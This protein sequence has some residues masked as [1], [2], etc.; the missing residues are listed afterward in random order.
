MTVIRSHAKALRL[1]VKGWMAGE[2]VTLTILPRITR[3]TRIKGTSR[4]KGF[5]RE[6]REIRGPNPFECLILAQCPVAPERMNYE[7]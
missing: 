1:K 2:S 6:I 4:L 5:I 3:I 7:L